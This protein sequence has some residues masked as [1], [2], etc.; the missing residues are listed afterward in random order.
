MNLKEANPVTGAL[1]LPMQK[2]KNF[3]FRSG[4][5][6]ANISHNHLGE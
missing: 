2:N 4:S 3:F 1:S 5:N 6:S